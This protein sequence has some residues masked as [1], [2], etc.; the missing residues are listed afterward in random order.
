MGGCPECPALARSPLPLPQEEDLL[1]V[2]ASPSSPGAVLG[3][4]RNQE[5]KSGSPPILDQFLGL[6]FPC[7]AQSAWDSKGPR[8]AQ[9]RNRQSPVMA[10]S[11]LA[12]HPP[13]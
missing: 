4:E 3:A 8:P 13:G 2:S 1:A 11:D 6:S 5:K 9:P 7:S 12:T 10:M